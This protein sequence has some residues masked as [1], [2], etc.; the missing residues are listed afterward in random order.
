[1]GTQQSAEDIKIKEAFEV[2]RDTLK[3][4]A[5][6]ERLSRPLAYWVQNSDRRMPLT[7]L[8]RSIGEIVHT[9][10][11][12]LARTP[13]VGPKKMASL[14]KLLRRVTSGESPPAEVVAPVIPA[15]P[16]ADG[17]FNPD[18]VCEVTWRQWRETIKNFGLE[19]EWLG[20][21]AP[22]LSRLPSV[23]WKKPLSFY[24]NQTLDDIR[25]LKTYG[26]KRVA[27]VLEVFH[28]LHEVLAGGKANPAFDV[29]VVPKFVGRIS[30]WSDTVH[31]EDRLP[32]RAELIEN[33]F[34]PILAQVQADVGETVVHLVRCRLG[35]GQSTI[36]VRQQSRQLGVTRARIYQ[37]LD[38]CQEVLAVRWPEG[39]CVFHQL[40]DHLNAHAADEMV[41][42]LIAEARTTFF[43]PKLDKVAKHLVANG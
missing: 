15:E 29:R 3:E 23:I 28:Q 35:I 13:G 6:A 42:N 34:E 4:P 41:L 19:S 33:V 36:S 16:I 38:E 8:D 39:R 37:M 2:I 9:S 32:D 22:S 18:A 30:R 10:F 11:Y 26:R 5:Y 43:P 7:F 14:V 24:L 17:E 25:S 21:V 12:D 31:A 20:R 40:K 27:V 1:M